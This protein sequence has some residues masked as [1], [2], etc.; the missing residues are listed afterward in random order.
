MIRLESRVCVMVANGWNRGSDP[1][2]ALV[3]HHCRTQ[4]CASALFMADLTKL[5]SL[6]VLVNMVSHLCISISLNALVVSQAFSVSVSVIYRCV[7]TESVMMWST[8]PCHWSAR[9]TPFKAVS[10][11]ARFMSCI[12]FWLK[13]PSIFHDGTVSFKGNYHG[14]WANSEFIPI[15]APISSYWIIPSHSIHGFGQHTSQG[16][17][18]YFSVPCWWHRGCMSFY[19]RHWE[20]GPPDLQK[21]GSD[22]WWQM[23]PWS[24]TSSPPTIVSVTADV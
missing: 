11:S 13:P 2:Q 15:D 3:S 24:V 14:K 12:I 9:L 8:L 5:Y 16:S 21:R 17:I 20:S 4:V 22:E 7:H 1:F 18:L 10:S 19:S 6:M 23:E